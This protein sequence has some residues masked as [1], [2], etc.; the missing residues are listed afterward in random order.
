[1]KGRSNTYVEKAIIGSILLKGGLYEKVM[2]RLSIGDF[3]DVL[4]Q[5]IW[6]IFGKFYEKQEPIDIISIDDYAYRHEISGVK[7]GTLKDIQADVSHRKVPVD[8]YVKR[9]K[10]WTYDR[11][12]LRFTKEFISGKITGDKLREELNNIKPLSEIKKETIE[13]IILATIADAEKGTDFKFPDN[14]EGLNE[15]TGG[16]D[17][18]DLII[19]GGY[20]S[21]GKSSMATDLTCGFCD[22]LGYSVLFI[23][24]EM[25]VKANM[26]RI[27]ACMKRINTMKFRRGVLDKEDKERIKEMIPL[28]SDIWNYNCIRAYNMQ[29]II[30]AEIEY[31]PDIVVIDYL[32]N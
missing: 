20:P 10:H 15:I 28:L 16:F 24:L 25:S 27:E 2:G 22:E 12:L 6:N 14:F 5:K 3:T 19:I 30:T 31:Q 18:G 29:D 17:R 21:S 4:Y 1:M 9:L 13:D 8:Q 32:Q 23:T 11:A 26:R 7:L